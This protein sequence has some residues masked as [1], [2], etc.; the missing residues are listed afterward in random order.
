MA[1]IEA[2]ALGVPVITVDE[3]DNA[4]KEL[5]T[6]GKNGF[7][8]GLDEKEIAGKIKFLLKNNNYEK[9][10]TRCI[11][12]SKDYDNHISAEKIMEVYNHAK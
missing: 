8:C 10:Y 1:I 12:S 11:N 5:V 9:F 2:N 4:A 3:K 6:N 7:V